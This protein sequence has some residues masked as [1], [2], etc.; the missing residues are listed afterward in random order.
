MTLH[1]LRRTKVL[2]RLAA[3]VFAM[4]AGIG[5]AGVEAAAAEAAPD[6]HRAL[7]DRYC[8][9]C[10]NDRQRTAGLTLESIDLAGV[11]ADAPVWE[12][13]MSRTLLVLS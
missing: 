5:L 10:H 6:A 12:K 7:L 8:V 9:T 2:W 1:G 13:G 11:A 4:A 3:F